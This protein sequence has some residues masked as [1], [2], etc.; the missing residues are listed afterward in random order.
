[1]SHMYLY[2]LKQLAI[3]N[4]G[5]ACR[6]ERAG[7]PRRFAPHNDEVGGDFRNDE[8]GISRNDEKGGPSQ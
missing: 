6:V 7:L 4:S 8:A 1:M 2:D 5:A 3:K